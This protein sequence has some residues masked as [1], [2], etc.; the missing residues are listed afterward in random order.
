MKYG[1][2]YAGRKFRTEFVG[3]VG[4]DQPVVDGVRAAGR[5]LDEFGLTPENAGNISVRSGRGMHITV[6]GVSKGALSADDIVEVVD[7]DF[8][9]AKVVGVKEPS[10]ETPMHWLIYQSYPDV[11]AVIHVHDDLAVDE[12]QKLER[13]CGIRSTE[14]FA[15][16]GTQE[17]AFQVVE[18]LSHCQYAVIK[19]HGV[20]CM[21]ESLDEAL[22]LIVS[23]HSG[24]CSGR[25]RQR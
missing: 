11:K 22:G 24:L 15:N 19:G 23:V 25:S 21:G 7:F 13:D 3:K 9:V 16:Y 12:A 8:H 20:V 2:E 18:A 10:S 4:A 17:Q 14:S 5:R 1:E 6:G